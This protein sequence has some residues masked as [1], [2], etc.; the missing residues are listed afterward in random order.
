MDEADVSSN[1]QQWNSDSDVVST[2]NLF[3]FIQLEELIE[4]LCM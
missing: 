2:I 4:L 1:K 3:E